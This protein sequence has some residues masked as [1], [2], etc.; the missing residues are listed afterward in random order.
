MT[1]GA[2]IF[3]ST[4][5]TLLA[6]AMAVRSVGARLGAGEESALRDCCQCGRHRMA[7]G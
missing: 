5:L 2:G 6:L 4:V 3:L 7:E 1:P